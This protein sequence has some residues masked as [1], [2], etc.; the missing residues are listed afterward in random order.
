MSHDIML[1]AY[2]T[3]GHLSLGSLVGFG[4]GDDGDPLVSD[5]CLDPSSNAHDE[6][7]ELLDTPVLDTRIRTH[8]LTDSPILYTRIHTS[9][10]SLE[11][12]YITIHMP[13]A[14]ATRDPTP[15]A[16]AYGHFHILTILALFFQLF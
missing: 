7:S 2:R 8:R 1:V 12:I 3:T 4:G 15:Q 16:S 5:G 6:F 14:R 10:S 13:N 11:S 9:L